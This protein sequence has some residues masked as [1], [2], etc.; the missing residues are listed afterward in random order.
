MFLQGGKLSLAIF[1]PFEPEKKHDDEHEQEE[2]GQGCLGYEKES[3]S[4]QEQIIH[5]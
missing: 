3:Y 1:P 5:R 4:F 2:D